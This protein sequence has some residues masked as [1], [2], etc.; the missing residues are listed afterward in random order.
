MEAG[1]GQGAKTA[2]G[3]GGMVQPIWQRSA[4]HTRSRL[5]AEGGTLEK[6]IG[7]IISQQ[8]IIRWGRKAHPQAIDGGPPG[9]AD[10]GS[11]GGRRDR[12][13]EG[14]TGA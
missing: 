3:G 1:A 13:R 10:C 14:V 5:L 2:R 11:M 8:K 6:E 9:A 4:P 12:G 7:I